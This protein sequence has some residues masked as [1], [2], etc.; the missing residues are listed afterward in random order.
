MTPKHSFPLSAETQFIAAC[1]RWPHDAAA[2]AAVQQT[3]SGISDWNVLLDACRR[4][5]VSGF[6]YNAIKQET[7][8]PPEFRAQLKKD[9]LR[10]AV[11]ANAQA[12]ETVRIETH[13]LENGINSIHFKGP[14]LSQ[15]AYGKLE[16]KQSNDLDMLVSAADV[17]AA[18]EKLRDLN[19]RIK[20]AHYPIQPVLC[21][22]LLRHRN[23][24]ELFSPQR[25]IVELHWQLSNAPGLLP[26]IEKDLSTQQ[27]ALGP[28]GSVKTLGDTDLF[29]YLCQHGALHD[30]ARLKWLV[31]VAAMFFSK[32][33][34][35]TAP[36]MQAA[37]DKGAG[38]A[39]TQA[40]LLCHLLFATPAPASIPQRTAQ[41]S[42]HALRRIEAPYTR[43]TLWEEIC[44][45]AGRWRVQR[46]FYPNSFAALGL[47][48][49]HRTSLSDIIAMPL[50]ARWDWLYPILRL[51]RWL[52]RSVNAKRS[53]R[54]T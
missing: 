37:H 20:G 4:H 28:H 42:E 25:M 50:S 10:A 3:I 49:V 39:A 8:V 11:Y 51:P 5:R 46:H 33:D 22:A 36:L 6:V 19:Y 12:K 45:N 52:I 34:S 27:V 54:K 26:N 7:G 18:I 48:K 41:L 23:Q 35:V 43:E 1:C 47:L 2:H 9:A 44:F 29:V 32:G 16:I 38:L 21:D 17:P 13:M 24:I 14:A 53:T 31:D 15:L 40:Q 30:W